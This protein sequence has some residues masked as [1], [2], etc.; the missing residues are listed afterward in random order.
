MK[1]LSVIRSPKEGKKWRAVFEK[2]D[3]RRKHTDF[4]AAGYQD[5]TQSKDAARATLYRDR[6]RKDLDT[7]DPT[8][9]GYLS[10]Y[11]LWSSPDFDANL[12]YYRRRFDL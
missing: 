8:R 4:G 9:A 3:G 1:L 7:N 2:P 6:H 5:Y 10:Y 12:R 11:L